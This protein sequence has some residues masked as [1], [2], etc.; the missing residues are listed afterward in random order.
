MSRKPTSIFSD[1]ETNQFR[2]VALEQCPPTLLERI[3]D[4]C[5]EPDNIGGNVSPIVAVCGPCGLASR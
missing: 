1:G 5:R 3:C 4:H 2:E